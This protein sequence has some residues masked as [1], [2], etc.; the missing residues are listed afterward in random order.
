MP[1]VQIIYSQKRG[2]KDGLACDD[3]AFGFFK[4]EA[5]SGTEKLTFTTNNPK[6]YYC[7][8]GKISISKDNDVTNHI[9]DTLVR[10]KGLSLQLQNMN[11]MI[12]KNLMRQFL[13]AAG[14]DE[15]MELKVP[16]YQFKIAPKTF[17]IKPREFEKLYSNKNLLLKRLYDPKRSL[18]KTWPIGA[19]SY[20]PD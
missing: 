4:D 3:Q 18:S 8:F 19:T 16:Q 6:S 9:T 10:C 14:R 13:E 15:R 17:E 11:G 12:T 5:S 1:P 7:E 20:Y 2:V